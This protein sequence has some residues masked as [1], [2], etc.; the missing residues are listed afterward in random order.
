MRPANEATSIASSRDPDRDELLLDLQVASATSLVLG[1]HLADIAEL[2]GLDRDSED[3]AIVPRV[4]ELVSDP[5]VQEVL[6]E[7][8]AKRRRANR[9]I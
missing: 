4:R 2:V 7:F 3:L 5:R 8:D 9:R 6:N 1:R